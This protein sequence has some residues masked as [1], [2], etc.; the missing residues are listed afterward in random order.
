MFFCR[1]Y[2]FNPVYCSRLCLDELV[3][4]EGVLEYPLDG[5][6]ED[7]LEVEAADL[8]PQNLQACERVQ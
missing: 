6:D 8:A 3:E 7:G 2:G 1:K 4:Y 5:L